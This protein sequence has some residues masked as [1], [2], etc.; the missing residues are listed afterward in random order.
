[1]VLK[2]QND[3]LQTEASALAELLACFK[4][5]SEQVSLDI[6][7]R[8]RDGEEPLDVLAAMKNVPEDSLKME[9][10]ETIFRARDQEQEFT[11][12]D[13][14]MFPA[15]EVEYLD[16]LGDEAVSSG[17]WLE[18]ESSSSSSSQ[19]SPQSS[20]ADLASDSPNSSHNSSE[21]S[22]P[23][24]GSSGSPS[25]G[26]ELYVEDPTSPSLANQLG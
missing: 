5:A 24:R 21:S 23:D 22:P 26:V 13:E 11:E 6:L 16:E 19:S 15:M 25:F 17:L 12:L 8:L 18:G 3:D 9:D 2:R 10:M 1:M 20:L 14:D 7:M 4:Y